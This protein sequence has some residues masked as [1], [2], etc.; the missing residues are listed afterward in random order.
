MSGPEAVAVVDLGFGDSGKGLCVDALARGAGPVLVVRFNGGAQAGH[1]VVAPDGRHHTFSQFGAATFVPGARTF[2]S[3]RMVVHPTALLFEARALAANGVA[4]AWER[5]AISES[6][7]VATPFHQALGRLRELARGD[8]RHGS[9]G[10]GVGEAVRDSLAP[11]AAVL[12]VGDLG[13]RAKT[14]RALALSQEA[15][16]AEARALG[17]GGAAADAELRLLDDPRAADAWLDRVAEFSRS[18]RVVDDDFLL[19]S[20]AEGGALI[21]EGAQ[22]VLLDERHGFHPHTTWSDCTFRGAEELLAGRRPLRRLGVLRTY[23]VR[24]GAGPFPT[25]D[26]AL[27]GRLHEAH[28]ADGPWQGPV[29]VGWPDWVLLRYALRACGG[30]DALALTYLD[31]LD[32]AREWRAAVAHE[33]AGEGRRAELPAAGEGEAER[34]GATRA[35]ARSRPEYRVL[36]LPGGA[37]SGDAYL[38]LL[39]DAAGVPVELSSRGPSSVSTSRRGARAL[40]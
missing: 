24:H 9:C 15:A 5:L 4:D 6:A 22:G 28:N 12:R 26:A 25:E 38:R 21:F 33:V 27:G 40:A 36:A 11:G 10:A 32:G 37:A 19:K 35:L 23:L 7:L 16:R 31:A 20:E 17:A 29:R 1:N 13:D 39:E 3:R 8:A 30:V 2:L 14:R 34:L 18:A